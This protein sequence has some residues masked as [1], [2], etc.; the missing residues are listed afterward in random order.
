MP[1]SEDGPSEAYEVSG[2]TACACCHSH[3]L[4]GGHSGVFM[5]VGRDDQIACVLCR[6]CAEVLDSGLEGALLVLKSLAFEFS[7]PPDCD[8]LYTS[9]P[10]S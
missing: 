2:V 7:S 6:L 4:S 5:P 1:E 9:G 8:G 10:P 3:D